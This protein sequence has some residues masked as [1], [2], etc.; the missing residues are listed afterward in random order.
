VVLLPLRQ[1]K[2]IFLVFGAGWC[3]P[4]HRLDDFLVEPEMR[5]ILEKYF[6]EARVN[7]LEDE[8][9]HPE[10]KSPGGQE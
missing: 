5:Q 7:V 2:A 3:Q 1:H 9:K 10:S 6:I 4:C 8:G